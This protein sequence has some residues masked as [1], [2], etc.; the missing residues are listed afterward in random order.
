M[1]TKKS[2]EKEIKVEKT[3]IQRYHNAIYN[4]G[5][6]AFN[7]FGENLYFKS[8]RTEKLDSNF[9]RS[10]GESLK[11]YGLEIETECWSISNSL[12]YGTFLQNYLFNIFPKHLF[13]I[14]Q[15]MSLRGGNVSGEC[16][17]QV[18]TQEFVRNHYANF[19]AMYDSFQD[20]DISCSRTGHCGMHINIS[21]A[22][23]GKTKEEQME[24][25]NK[26]YYL[27]NKHY[28]LFKNLYLR[29][30]TDYCEQ[31]RVSKD[32]AKS[33]TERDYNSMAS[34]SCCL[35]YSHFQD[36]RIELRLPSGQANF[37]DFRNTMELTFHLVNVIKILTWEQLDNIEEIFKNCNEFVLQRLEQKGNLNLSTL[38]KIREN[39]KVSKNIK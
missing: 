17:S 18:M 19:K 1:A 34:H 27:I 26:F 21:N 5:S 36:G 32:Y 8:D 12:V 11:G 25:I 35:N 14:Q 15:D 16:I 33:L 13:K 23:F 24:N 7:G 22:L 39:V 4:N 29:K 20:F 28:T 31:M 3:N 6:Y 37:N 38:R 2:Y 10:N 30:C 9:R